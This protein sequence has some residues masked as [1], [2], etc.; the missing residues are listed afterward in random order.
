[1]TQ[2]LKVPSC[3]RTAKIVFDTQ[4]FNGQIFLE[5]RTNKP[6]YLTAFIELRFP[7][8]ETMEYIEVMDQEVREFF[9][10]VTSD[11]K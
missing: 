7:V 2:I 5:N 8:P 10:E 3:L 9:K 4:N 6:E 11:R 1:M